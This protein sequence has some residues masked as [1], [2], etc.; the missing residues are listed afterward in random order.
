MRRKLFAFTIC[1]I[2][3][4]VSAYYI[5][6][7]FGQ[8]A[9][10]GVCISLAICAAAGVVS[11]SE[12][13]GRKKG[14]R[15]FVLIFCGIFCGTLLFFCCER[16]KAQ[17]VS[18]LC[19]DVRMRTAEVISVEK[20]SAEKYNLLCREQGSKVLYRYYADIPG[21]AELTGKTLVFSASAKL[22]EEAK[23]PRVFDYRLY[24]CTEKIFCVGEIRSFTV[25]KQKNGI[26]AEVRRK[27]IMKKEAF[28]HRMNLSPGAEGLLRGILFGDTGALDEEIYREFRENGTAHVLAVSGLHV[29]MLY[30]VYR[31]LIGRRRSLLSAAGLFLLLL[32]YGTV[33]LW[34]VSVSRAV[35]LVM[36]SAAADILER[37]YDPLT[38]LSFAALLA[39]VK[40]PYVIFGAGFQMSFL[41]VCSMVFFQPVLRKKLPDAAA[42]MIS[43][44]AGLLPYMAFNFNSVSLAGFFVNPPVVFLVSL[45][46]PAGIVTYLF[47]LFF[48]VVFSPVCVAADGLANMLIRVNHML[49]ADGLLVFDAVSPPLWALMAFYCAAFYLTSEQAFVGFHRSGLKSLRI[50]AALLAAVILFFSAAERTDFDRASLVFVDVGQG[51]CLHIKIDEGRNAL[52]DGGGSL[53]YNIG[54]KT[55]KPYLLKNGVDKVDF[56]AATHLHTDHYLGLAQLCDCYP[57][58]KL[59]TR[60]RAGQRISLGEDQW[61]EILW[62]LSQEEKIVSK[63]VSEDENLT[64]LIF[65]VYDKGITALITGDIT[66]EGENLLL[67]YYEGTDALSADIL[68]VAHHGSAYSSTDE[69]IRAVNPKVAVISV[70][71]NNYGHPAQVVIEKLEKQGIMV[72]RTDLHGAVGIISRKGSFSVCTK[73]K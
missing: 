6:E 26:A 61:I 20:L 45:L 57:V 21:Y 47:F 38:A 54:E 41:A 58:K 25:A 19:G 63:S 12:A 9:L 46:V 4:I 55:L 34:S 7:K 13:G 29:G 67:K 73:N 33:T 30:A 70:G 60:G 66:A 22:A 1:V 52:I 53:S 48:G 28:L 15:A 2:I 64:S 16:E 71:R 24:L 40:N 56:A 23:N 11:A 44:Q 36:L 50:P 42:L 43:V 51:D 68:K 35:L 62:P 37:R 8:S 27:L 49:S 69:F 18:S 17:A 31:K 14:K 39:A 10:V 3:G 65:K 59:M 32:L 5:S 72:Y